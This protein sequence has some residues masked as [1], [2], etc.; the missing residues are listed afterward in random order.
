MHSFDVASDREALRATTVLALPTELSVVPS[1]TRSSGNESIYLG[2]LGTF[3]EASS[4]QLPAPVANQRFDSVHLLTNRVEVETVMAHVWLLAAPDGQLLTSISV[5]FYGGIADAIEVLE[6]MYY[7]RIM[8]PIGG[9]ADWVDGQLSGIL[10]QPAEFGNGF[11]PDRH[12]LLFIGATEG[13]S[14]STED[15]IQ[16]LV[17]R[18]DLPYVKEHSEI[19]YPGELNRRPDARCALSPFVSV[20]IGQ[21]DYIENMAWMSAAMITG[22]NARLRHISKDATLALRS[23]RDTSES[24]NFQ[25]ARRRSA[26]LSYQLSELQLDLSFSVEALADVGLLVPSLRVQAYHRSLAEATGMNRRTGVVAQMLTRLESAVKAMEVSL[27]ARQ[28]EEDDIRRLRWSVPVAVLTAIAVPS[29]ILFGYF[30]ANVAEVDPGVSL[31]DFAEHSFIYLTLLAVVLAGASS[32][33]FVHF[34]V[35]RRRADRAKSDQDRAEAGKG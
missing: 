4:D 30:G 27:A 31:F 21:Q 3:Y 32:A 25:I 20:F 8:L 6:A 26:D 14:L 16:R 13:Q 29:G 2:R 18:A 24:Q 11:T 22:A 19:L 33:L 28:R 15:S 7:E 9:L 10:K 12:Q 1:A 35:V 5:D 17:Y 23:F 34:A